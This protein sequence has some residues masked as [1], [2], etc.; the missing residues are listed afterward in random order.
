[1]EWLIGEYWP[2][3]VFSAVLGVIASVA[4]TLRKVEVHTPPEGEAGSVEPEPEPDEKQSRTGE[5]GPGS[6][7]PLDDGGAPDPAYTVKGIAQSMVFHT[8]ES[9]YFGRARAEVW[10]DSEETARAAGFVRWDED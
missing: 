5:L 7:S 2:W 1:M 10:F 8:P 4:F 6:A 3:L 9:P